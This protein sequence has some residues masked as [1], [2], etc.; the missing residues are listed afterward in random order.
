MIST[1]S[2]TPTAIN[3]LSFAILKK[4]SP[5]KA[6]SWIIMNALAVW[7]GL[8]RLT[9]LDQFCA[10]ITDNRSDYLRNLKNLR[11]LEICGGG[12]TD[13]VV[14]NI[15]DLQSLV[16]LNLSQNCHSQLALYEE[17]YLTVALGFDGWLPS[18][19]YAGLTLHN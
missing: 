4:V 18:F 14:K 15:K 11:S 7:I 10:K 16:R 9:H 1:V 3:V 8:T 13:V 5:K 12:I 6:F 19:P 2:G 17:A